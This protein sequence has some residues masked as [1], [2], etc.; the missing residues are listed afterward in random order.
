ME[1]PRGLTTPPKSRGSNGP[2]KPAELNEQNEL[3]SEILQADAPK[4]D[5]KR[6]GG[7]K[8]NNFEAAAETGAND[9]Q[10]NDIQVNDTEANDSDSSFEDPDIRSRRPDVYNGGVSN[11]AYN[12]YVHSG[13]IMRT[14]R[15]GP[16]GRPLFAWVTRLYERR[17]M[18]YYP[19]SLFT[20]RRG[21]K[22]G[23]VTEQVSNTI[24]LNGGFFSKTLR[25]KTQPY[26]DEREIYFVQEQTMCSYW[27]RNRVGTTPPPDVVRR[28]KIPALPM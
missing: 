7:L 25:T 2:S 19:R 1:N 8:D 17:S 23:M 12:P 5:D 28:V 16:D 15:H 22:R 26:Y 9:A 6:D 18:I 24:K 20:G 21:V 27:R 11:S 4:P 13:Q 14:A 10:A 3:E